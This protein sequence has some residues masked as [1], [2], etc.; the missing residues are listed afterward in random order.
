MLGVAGCTQDPTSDLGGTPTRIVASYAK[1]LMTV[2]DTVGVTAE[3]RDEQ[4]APLDL[5]PVASAPTPTV[6][7][8]VSQQQATPQPYLQLSVTG[9]AAGAGIIVLSYENVAD[10]I[11]VAVF[12]VTFDGAVTVQTG[13]QLDTVAIAAGSVVSFDPAA[14]TVTIDGVPARPL[15]VTANAITVLARNTGAVAAAKVTLG[16]VIFL[17][18]TADETPIQAIDAETTPDIRGEVNEPA[19]AGSGG[20]TVLP[21]GGV[22]EGLVS[23]SDVDDYFSFVVTGGP[24]DVTISVAFDGDGGDPDID[25]YLLGPAPVDDNFCAL[26][27]CGMGTGAQPQEGTFTL[28]SGTYYVLVEWFAAGA[29]TPPHYYKLTVSGN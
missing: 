23:S 13:G 2:G 27:A 22:A 21:A 25:V 3:L 18:G 17:A 8:V 19:N 4:G 9:V 16:N 6:V 7:D 15:S 10:T 24:K 1:L 14:T 28:A 11:K 29:D 26:D 12:P 5:M 20:A